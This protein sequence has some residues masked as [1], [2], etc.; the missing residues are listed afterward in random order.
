MRKQE[1]QSPVNPSE[2]TPATVETAGGGQAT[3]TSEPEAVKSLAQL[4]D[5][6]SI[7][8]SADPETRA[9]GIRAILKLVR[10]A[11]PEEVEPLLRALQVQQILTGRQVET[12]LRALKT[13][14]VELQEK[15]QS[16]LES[17]AGGTRDGRRIS[18]R[19]PLPR[20]S[21]PSFSPR[22]PGVEET[23]W[24]RTDDEPIRWN[25]A[26]GKK[27]AIFEGEHTPTSID[28][29]ETPEEQIVIDRQAEC[30]AAEAHNEAVIAAIRSELD[31]TSLLSG[32]NTGENGAP[33]IKLL[34]HGEMRAR[35]QQELLD[36][37]SSGPDATS[38]LL[39]AS[40]QATRRKAS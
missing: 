31:D 32:V 19:A 2:G 8:T 18:R 13:A 17:L 23:P 12:L 26:P 30:R 20:P 36:R 35:A 6:R 27:V 1:V 24:K 15:L 3:L 11:A 22:T 40:D 38:R 7:L 33:F 37:R 25:A 34:S 16:E 28:A 21:E 39:N 5:L 14:P 10:E 9:S 4:G 29:V